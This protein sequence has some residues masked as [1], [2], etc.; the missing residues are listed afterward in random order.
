[1]TPAPAGAII[2]VAGVMAVLGARVDHG[3]LSPG[4]IPCD[5]AR[6]AAQSE[7]VMKCG[8]FV[9]ICGHPMSSQH[10]RGCLSRSFCSAQPRS[11]VCKAADAASYPWNPQ[12]CEECV[13]RTRCSQTPTPRCQDSGMCLGCVHMRGL[14]VKLGLDS[15]R[16]A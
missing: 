1:V 14:G 6:E 2:G 8:I 10:G 5:T 9:G 3:L 7:S 4:V 16:G 12:C 11:R 15:G 13:L